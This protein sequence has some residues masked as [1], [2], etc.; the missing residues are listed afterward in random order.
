MLRS[1]GVDAPVLIPEKPVVL[2]LEENAVFRA[3]TAGHLIAA[4][5]EV[6]EAANSADAEQIL[7]GTAVDALVGNLGVMRA[8]TG[9]ERSGG[10]LT[11]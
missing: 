5:F 8:G 9:G 2:V 10:V 6:F 11:V 1:R 3:I 4:G 7:N